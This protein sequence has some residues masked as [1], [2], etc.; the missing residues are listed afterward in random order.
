MKISQLIANHQSLLHQA[1]LANLAQAYA[2]LH[3]LADR[4]R[5]ARLAGPVNLRQ[6]DAAEGRFW[7]SLTALEGSQSVLEEHFREEELMEFADAVAFVRGTAELNITFRLE[8]M[9]AEFV[10]PLEAELRRAGISLDLA[11]ER[12]RSLGERFAWLPKFDWRRGETPQ[13]R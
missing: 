9:T 6:P 11:A 4:V 1:R 5:R 3:H 10:E 8:S 2:T 7:A 13:Q 12:R